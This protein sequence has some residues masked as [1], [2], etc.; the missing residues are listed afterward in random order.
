MSFNYNIAFKRNIGWLTLDEQNIL[1]N[2]TVAIGGL[3][4]V[5]GDH[6]ITLARLGVEN[7]NIADFDVFDYSNFNRQAGATV[8]TVGKSKISVTEKL[9]LDVNPNIKIKKFAKGITPENIDQFLEGADIYV[10][11]LDV[12]ALDIRRLVFSKCFDNKIPALS[13]APM[14]MGV[15]FTSFLPEKGHSFDKYFGMRDITPKQIK[16]LDGDV[17]ETNMLKVEIYIDNIVRFL[18]GMAPTV[19][20]RHYLIENNGVD[21][22]AK[23]LPSTKMGIDLA[24]GALCTN[25]LKILLN[26]GRVVSAPCVIHYDAYLNNLKK[27]WCPLGANTPRLLIMRQLMWKRFRLEEKLSCVKGILEKKAYSGSLRHDLKTA[28]IFEILHEAKVS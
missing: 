7:F 28:E 23:D 20:Q 12:F 2:T 24:A 11:S 14:G 19:Q 8:G 4:G 1:K 22:F 15:S 27:T 13:A 21:L 25:V 26:R 3:G 16:N 5:G 9:L 18:T 10:D 17:V 6:A